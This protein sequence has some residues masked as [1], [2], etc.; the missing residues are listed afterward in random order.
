MNARRASG[1]PVAIA[2]AGLF[3]LSTP[4]ASEC[5]GPWTPMPSFTEVAPTAE[6]VVVGT[7]VRDL[8]NTQGL[9][10]EGGVTP[11]F[12]MEVDT[13]LRGPDPGR[14]LTMD[15]VRTGVP[16]TGQCGSP[17][18]VATVGD[19]IAVAF[20]GRLPGH[21]RPITAVA[22]ITGEPDELAAEK[23]EVLTMSEVRRALLPLPDTST[24]GSADGWWLST[25]L[26][27]LL[28]AGRGANG[29]PRNEEWPG[30]IPGPDWRSTRWTDH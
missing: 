12:E 2:L 18:V 17:T 7:V 28:D 10:E 3:T 16:Q 15:I 20:D 24:A 22:W 9:D 25:H 26:R 19:R 6:R 27:A 11:S 4:V 5:I 30:E 29:T 8:G 13:V 14:T 23:A 21:R 1:I